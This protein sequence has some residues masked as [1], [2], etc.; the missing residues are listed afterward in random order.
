MDQL[1]LSPEDEAIV[2]ECRH[3]GEDGK[4]QWAPETPLDVRRRYEQVVRN[5]QVFSKTLLSKPAAILDAYLDQ[6][7]GDIEKLVQ[8]RVT[9][10][11]QQTQQQ[12]T[13]QQALTQ[14]L[15]ANPW[16]VQLDPRTNQPMID[17]RDNF[18]MFSE[19]G[20]KV[21]AQVEHLTTQYKMPLPEALSMAMAMAQTQLGVT[22][23][24]PPPPPQ[25]TLQDLENQRKQQQ[26]NLLRGATNPT[27]PGQGGFQNGTATTTNG[28]YHRN[29]DGTVTNAPARPQNAQAGLGLSMF[30][31]MGFMPSR[32]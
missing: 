9:Q 7:M 17:P 2:L 22:S 8:E 26:Q 24:T 32:Q 4:A 11:L 6:K 5:R 14:A 20:E 25:P 28:Q 21:F 12:Q 1:E 3:E 23:S 31:R 10:V 29:P 15:T 16:M 18:P 13:E 27:P 30:D 19:A